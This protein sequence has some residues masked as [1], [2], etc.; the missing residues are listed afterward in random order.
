MIHVVDTSN[1]N[2]APLKIDE[3]EK[4]LPVALVKVQCHENGQEFGSTNNGETAWNAIE[5][6]LAH[7]TRLP[8]QS[9]A[10]ERILNSGSGVKGS[11]SVNQS[12]SPWKRHMF[13]VSRFFFTSFL[14][15]LTNRKIDQQ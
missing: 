2:Y 10:L 15:S 5:E 3:L 14:I 4:V 9:V 12:P 8:V 11:A 1:K 6:V 13:T 7:E